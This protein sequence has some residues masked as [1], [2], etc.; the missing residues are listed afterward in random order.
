MGRKTQ[1]ILI[2]ILKSTRSMDHGTGSTL[3]TTMSRRKFLPP[4]K[5]EA[6]IW[7]TKNNLESSI[8]LNQENSTSRLVLQMIEV[9]PLMETSLTSNLI[10]EKI[11]ISVP[12]NKLMNTWKMQHNLQCQ[13]NVIVVVQSWHLQKILLK[14]LKLILLIGNKDMNPLKNI[15]FTVGLKLL[16]M[17]LENP[18]SS[19]LLTIKL[20]T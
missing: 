9:T 7:N 19:D 2:S 1:F 20:M 18:W 6:Q 11:L 4:L 15:Q 10:T 17:L 14:P 8:T 3:A 5:E 13:R 16:K 12:Q